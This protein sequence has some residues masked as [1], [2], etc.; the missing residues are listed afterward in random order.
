MDGPKLRGAV[1]EL[2]AVPPRSGPSLTDR[3]RRGLSVTYNRAVEGDRR[4]RC[5][6]D[7]RRSYPPDCE[8]E[9][10]RTYVYRV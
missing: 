5:D 4:L 8:R 6:A 1:E 3:P 2:V 7:R 9:P 10:G